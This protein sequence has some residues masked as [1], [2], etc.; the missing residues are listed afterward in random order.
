[1]ASF[2]SGRWGWWTL[3]ILPCMS[4]EAVNLSFVSCFAASASQQP[5][6]RNGVMKIV[7]LGGVKRKTNTSPGG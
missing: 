1:M 4:D 6:G 3:F 7:C 2:T 5:A